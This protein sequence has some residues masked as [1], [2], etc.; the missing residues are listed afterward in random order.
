MGNYFAVVS[1]IDGSDDNSLDYELNISAQVDQTASD[2][3]PFLTN[4]DLT[5]SLLYETNFTENSYLEEEKYEN[6]VY[7]FEIN[8]SAELLIRVC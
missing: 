6:D 8:E 7:K 4:Y 2:S 3:L 1:Y 5:S